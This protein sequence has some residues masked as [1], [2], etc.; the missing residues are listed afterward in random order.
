MRFLAMMM[1]FALG[2]TALPAQDQPANN[3]DLVR[4]KVKAD[5][6]LVVAEAM[7]L[8]ETESKAFWPV[9]DAYQGDI[10]KI[11]Q[12]T[13]KLIQD[14]AA[15]YKTMTDPVAGKLLDEAIAIERDRA[16]LF[17]TYRPKFSAVLPATKVARYYQIENKIRAA[18]NYDLAA[19]IPIM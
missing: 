9:Y 12:R 19:N 18:I 14:Y 1:V 15:S 4:E 8:T 7:A 2:A 16:A 11:N 17:A 6:K 3:M 10:G 13:V 5:K